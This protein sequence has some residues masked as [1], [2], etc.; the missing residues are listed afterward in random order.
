MA[1]RSAADDDNNPNSY[2]CR[3]FVGNIPKSMTNADLRVGAET[4]FKGVVGLIT[5]TVPDDQTRNRG[6]CFIEFASNKLAAQ[7]KR[8]LIKTKFC[9]CRV[10]ADWADPQPEPNSDVMA[11]VKVLYI[12]NLVMKVTDLELKVAFE[13]YGTV[14]RVK[15]I[16]DYAFIHFQEREDAINAMV[17]LNGH[18]FHSI[19]I[20]VVLAKPPADK[21]SREDI[22]KNRERRIA[23]ITRKKVFN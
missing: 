20:E 2:N 11:T 19:A 7:A 9:G 14:E 10:L 21:K 8:T 15:R 5:Y 4:L 3:L 22:L 16:R 17:A 18:T 12:K 23:H 13:Q 6:F 1:Q